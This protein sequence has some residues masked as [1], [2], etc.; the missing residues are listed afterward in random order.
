MDTL[1]PASKISTL[2]QGKFVGAVTDNFNERIQQKIF[3][4]EIVVNNE[5]VAQEMKNYKSIPQIKDFKDDDGIDRMKEIIE[6]NY[7]K[8]KEDV[9][10][11]VS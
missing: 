2:T 11:I 4:S 9:K 6:A 3:H 1:I 7:Y 5:K 8:I 10:V